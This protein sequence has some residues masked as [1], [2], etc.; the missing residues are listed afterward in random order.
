[1]AEDWEIRERLKNSVSNE[2]GSVLVKCAHC[3][4]DGWN[5]ASYHTCCASYSGLSG[6][7][8]ANERAT[9]C[10]CKGTGFNRV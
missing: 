5:T 1:M 2:D 9:C 7:F 3:N 10:V 4:G 8:G 6:P